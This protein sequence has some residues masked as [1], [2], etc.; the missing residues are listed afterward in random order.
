MFDQLS[1]NPAAYNH[2]PGGSNVLYLDGH[3]DFLRYEEFGTAPVNG[4][5]ATLVGL[6]TSD[7]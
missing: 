6:L 1:T 2:V 5:M 4:P 7:L 3:V